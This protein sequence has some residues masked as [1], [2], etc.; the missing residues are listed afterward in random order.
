MS[1]LRF[2]IAPMPHGD[3]AFGIATPGV[4]I[5]ERDGG[6]QA[7]R[8]RFLTIAQAGELRCG[9]GKALAEMPPQDSE[10]AGYWGCY[11]IYRSAA[12]AA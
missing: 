5:I 8:V 3:P 2:T 1:A 12:E 6:G 7:E 10:A 9:I 4:L 11:P